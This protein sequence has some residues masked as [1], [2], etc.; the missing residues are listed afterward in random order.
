M[1]RLCSSEIRITP[2]EESVLGRLAS[3][4]ALRRE[5]MTPTT[6]L[7]PSFV[8]RISR[9]RR[10]GVNSP[11]AILGE[12]YHEVGHALVAVVLNRRVI[13]VSLGDGDLGGHVVHPRIFS[14]DARPA[15]MT[16]RHEWFILREVMILSAGY[17]AEVLADIPDPI[18]NALFDHL[19]I[20]RLLQQLEPNAEKRRKFHKV[21]ANRAGE[22][23]HSA[24]EIVE[25]LVVELQKH[26]ELSGNQ[27]RAI[28]KA[29]QA[30]MFQRRRR[31]ASS[32]KRT[33]QTRT[34]R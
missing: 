3:K 30:R 31:H 24:W 20:D 10:R 27:I 16:A 19:K 33:N 25:V 29:E 23:L 6:K 7:L 34:T 15:K 14:L 12:I 13:K 18:D 17:V 5:L 28:V 4:Q 32:K 1:T 21:V 9:S 8:P 26:Y 11:E 2:L 22:L